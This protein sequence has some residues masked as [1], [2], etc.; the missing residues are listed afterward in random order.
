MILN[1][2]SELHGEPSHLMLNLFFL[3]YGGKLTVMIAAVANFP[4]NLSPKKRTH[5]CENSYFEKVHETIP[6]S[7]VGD[8]EFTVF[9]KELKE[10]HERP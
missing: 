5:I 8:F 2:F 10:L 3:F 9:L 4:W 7:I 1:E 6:K